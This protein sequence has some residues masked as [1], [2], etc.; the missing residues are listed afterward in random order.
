MEIVILYL[1]STIVVFLSIINAFLW[2]IFLKRIKIV[3]NNSI[4]ERNIPYIYNYLHHGIVFPF[5]GD[6]IKQGNINTQI[7]QINAKQNTSTH[8]SAFECVSVNSFTHRVILY[9]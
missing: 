4:I 7:R 6:L 8:R 5:R 9:F 1:T 2:N 3:R